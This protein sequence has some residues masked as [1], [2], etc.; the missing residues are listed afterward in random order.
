MGYDFS[1]HPHVRTDAGV[2]EGSR[3]SAFWGEEYVIAEMKFCISSTPLVS[4]VKHMAARTFKGKIK[5][6]EKESFFS[7]NFNVYINLDNRDRARAIDKQQRRQI[8]LEGKHENE[9][10]AVRKFEMLAATR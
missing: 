7:L 9:I 8:S 1:V 3:K 10:A 5:I 6:T 2:G 4:A